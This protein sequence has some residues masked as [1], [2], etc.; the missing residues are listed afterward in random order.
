MAMVTVRARVP[1]MAC[2]EGA[3]QAIQASYPLPPS[4]APPAP[5][6]RHQRRTETGDRR[7]EPKAKA[8]HT[9]RFQSGQP[10]LLLAP[11]ST[12]A[13]AAVAAAEAE[14]PGRGRDRVR[15][16]GPYDAHGRAAV[17]LEVS[18]CPT[19]RSKSSAS[20]KRTP[21]SPNPPKLHFRIILRPVLAPV[22][23]PRARLIRNALFPLVLSPRACGADA[24]VC[25]DDRLRLLRCFRLVVHILVRMPYYHRPLVRTFDRHVISLPIFKAEHIVRRERIR[26]HL[27]GA[28]PCAAG[29]PHVP[30]RSTRTN[31]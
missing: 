8:P 17:A 19:F 18:H 4:S 10:R 26:A 27:D 7:P 30:L 13:V 3:A 25:R 31:T 20:R 5:A 2:S 14:F 15:G 28:G 22:F 9:K 29:F 1:A 6:S 16:H 12:R 21:P 11:P 24:F 23:T